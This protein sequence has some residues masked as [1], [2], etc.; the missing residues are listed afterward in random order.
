MFQSD[1]NLL[2]YCAE[3]KTSRCLYLENK[4][5]SID[6]TKFQFDPLLFLY[7]LKNAS[8][9]IIDLQKILRNM[10]YNLNLLRYADFREK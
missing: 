7:V 3:L 9:R 8:K 6:I 1:M 2:D 10:E 5:G 4:S